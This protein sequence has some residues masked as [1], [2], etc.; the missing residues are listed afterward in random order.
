[1]AH[2]ITYDAAFVGDVMQGK[3]LPTDRWVKVTLPVPV[4]NVLPLTEIQS[5]VESDSSN[6]EITSITDILRPVS[7]SSP[8]ARSGNPSRR[9]VCSSGV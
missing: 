7:V 2:T 6:A 8:T 3:P 1:M 5:M 9:I 4:V